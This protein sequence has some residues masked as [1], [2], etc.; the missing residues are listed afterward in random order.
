MS[1]TA[2]PIP[3]T[4]RGILTLLWVGIA[5]AIVAAL[6]L[7]W[8]GTAGAVAEKGSNEQF[9][10]YNKSRP[11]VVETESG[12]QYQVL[13]KGTGDLQPTDADVTL[14]QYVGKLR[15]GSIFDASKQ[16][17]PLPV[18]GVVKGFGEALKRM[19]KG[20]K[21]RAWIKPE[22]G[23]GAQSPSPALPANSLLVFEIELLDFLPEALLR[24]A[25]MQQQMQQMQ[26]QGAAPGGQ[27]MQQAP[28]VP[29][30]R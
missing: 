20:E 25:Q 19:H 14:I 24:Q 1:I 23:Y 7:A 4:K 13:K 27:P 8:A 29:P 3:P 18:T 5:V 21:I 22:L 2:V 11:G 17:T 15:D 12:L 30:Q 16:P 26:Q 9:L 10:A 28:A 6:A